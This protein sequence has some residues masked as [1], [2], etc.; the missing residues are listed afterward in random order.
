[1]QI[2]NMHLIR[3]AVAINEDGTKRGVFNFVPESPSDRP[4][5]KQGKKVLW[6]T[7]L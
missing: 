5:D 4:K 6:E 1:M 7:R 3:G 2:T